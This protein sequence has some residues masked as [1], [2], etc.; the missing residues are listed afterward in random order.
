MRLLITLSFVLAFLGVNARQ[1]S[2]DEAKEFAQNF[3]VNKTGI[4]TRGASEFEG[5][6]L[7]LISVE[8][9][10][11]YHT[12][13]I[14]GGKG[15][16]LVNAQGEKP[17]ILGYSDKGSFEINNLPPQLKGILSDSKNYKDVKSNIATRAEGVGIVYNTAEW[18][19]YEPF[20]DLAPNKA[21]AGCVATA[22]AITM[23]FHQ[24]PDR[25]RG[26]LQS[27]WYF[28]ELSLDFNAY[29]IDWNSLSDS[30]N[31][32]FNTEAAKLLKSAGIASHMIYGAEEF[33]ESGAD[34]WA[35]SNRLIE[36]YAYG[37]DC[38]YVQKEMFSEEDWNSLLKAQIK[39]VGPVIYRGGSTTSHCFVI[40]GYDSEGYFHVNWGWDG[41]SNGYYALDFSDVG[42]LDF[43][44]YQGMV[45]NIVPDKEKREYSK[46]FLT[47]SSVYKI[48]DYKS[49]VW[50]FSTPDIDNGEIVY[51]ILPIVTLNGQQGYFRIGIVDENDN[52]VEVLGKEPKLSY[53][54]HTSFDTAPYCSHPGV[55]LEYR[56]AF[57]PLKEGQRYQL[58]TQDATYN[59]ETG[60]ITPNSPSSNP[61]DY[62]LVLGG[63]FNPAHFYA[64]GNNSDHV[65]FNIHVDEDMPVWFEAYNT[66]E[67]EFSVDILRHDGFAD[68]LS[69]PLKGDSMEVIVTDKDGNVKEPLFSGYRHGYNYDMNI[70]AYEDNYDVYFK[71]QKPDNFRNDEQL[72]SDKIYEEN[73]LVY[74]IRDR[75]VSLIGYDKNKIGEKITIPDFVTVNDQKLNLVE[76]NHDALLLAPITD[77][78]IEASHLIFLGNNAFGGIKNLENL[79][80]KNM[81]SYSDDYYNRL[82]F[83]T[84]GIKNIYFETSPTSSLAS[85]LFIYGINTTRK[86]SREDVNVYLSAVPDVLNT[87]AYTNTWA[88]LSFIIRD[89]EAMDNI[90]DALNIPG[91]GNTNILKEMMDY[92]FP[93]KQM[94]EYAIDRNQYLLSLSKVA[95]NVKIDEVSINGTVI[96]PNKNGYYQIPPDGIKPMEVIVKYTVNG[97]K[98]M[99]TTYSA[100]YNNTVPSVTLDA[101]V[102]GIIDD[103]EK[104]VDV[105][106]L[107][108]VRVLHNA[109]K[110]QIKSLKSGVYVVGDKKIVVK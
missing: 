76:V 12:F 44:D 82:P 108:G 64:K 33:S 48:G 74:E 8:S 9:K 7:K 26:G 36:L 73:G 110:D 24:W 54:Y 70:S 47:N 107:Q 72:S 87:Y 75:A 41:Y 3:L 11:P 42:G 25:T 103:T 61:S 43:G 6:K 23:Q 102:E 98:K 81:S 89:Q 78:N 85:D 5:E 101:G 106:N 96:T 22:M 92:N 88:Y 63:M 95:K 46:A 52:I 32:K 28:P 34:V 77:L 31:P 39:E 51:F 66:D 15:F 20:N 21:A 62:K 50:N 1:I 19:Q 91:L 13:N 53:N 49:S 29:K 58:I 93:V 90:M 99:T 104:P 35:I 55:K 68:N 83:L 65:K 4:H 105:Y 67:K 109:T 71:Y 59:T 10:A 17:M 38:Q 57:P 97:T 94:W 86:A 100:G 60:E 2:V 40:D 16:V 84:S 37:K 56:M 80:I 30:Q 18:G 79:S 69:L 45:I 14:D 27:D